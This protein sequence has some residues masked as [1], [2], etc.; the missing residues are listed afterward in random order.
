MPEVK[1][2]DWDIA[3][4][5]AEPLKQVDKDDSSLYSE[6]VLSKDEDRFYIDA[7]KAFEDELAIRGH[8]QEV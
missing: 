4:L 2:T 3:K 1:P 8:A 7:I 5:K 6:F